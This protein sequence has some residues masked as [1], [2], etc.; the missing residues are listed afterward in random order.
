PERDVTWVVPVSAP[1]EHA[2]Q[3]TPPLGQGGWD[4][5]PLRRRNANSWCA[6][7]LRP[8]ALLARP[9][10][11]QELDYH[12]V[13]DPDARGPVEF[14]IERGGV[15]HGLL[16]WFDTTLTEGVCFSN[17]PGRPELIY[18]AAFFPWPEAVTLAAGERLRAQ[19][20]ARLVGDHYVWRW[21]TEVRD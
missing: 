21:E 4:W 16:A 8:E 13:Q 15:G 17:A 2:R 6:C 14:E 19:L 20:E 9:Q 10:P 5:G 11:W 1:D 12:S 7:H 18:S 3:V